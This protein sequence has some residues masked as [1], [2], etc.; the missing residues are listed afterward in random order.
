M[1]KIIFGI[2]ILLIITVVFSC[3]QENSS[4]TLESMKKTLKNA[5]YTIIE[6]YTELYKPHED[7]IHSINGFSFVFSGAHGNIN[8]PV[9][10]F[11]DNTS[12]KSY[13]KTV[14]SSGNFLAIKNDKFIIVIEAHG[15]IA[16]DEDKIFFDNLITGKHIK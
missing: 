4:V 2:S 7:S 9:L 11:E 15:G 8:I 14:N 1:K 16:H 13:A 10:E 12:A 5:R 6:N 3:K